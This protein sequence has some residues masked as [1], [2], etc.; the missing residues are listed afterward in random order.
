MDIAKCLEDGE[1]YTAVNFSRLPTA[2]IERKRRL[3]RCPECKGPAFFRHASFNGRAPCFG[4]RPHAL[5]CQ[6]AAQEFLLDDCAGYNRGALHIPDS[7]IIVDLKY[8]APVQRDNFR[9]TGRSPLQESVGRNY[10]QPNFHIYHRRLGPLLR[11]LIESPAFGNSDQ[12]VAI[13]DH[14]EYAARDFFLPLQSATY[15][16]SGIFRGYWGVLSDAKLA[17]DN[18]LWLNS[19]GCDN[20]SFCLDSRYV[21]V[22]V[23]RYGIKDLEEIAGAYILVIGTPRVAQN[24]KLYCLIDDPEYMTLRLT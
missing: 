15:Q 6:L 3:L 19:G 1:I 9:G 18:S 8:G 14:G 17:P 24:G 21:D 20:I 11:T 23:Q 12:I 7:K 4:A 16:Y 13:D 5:G 22:I 2:D 10:S